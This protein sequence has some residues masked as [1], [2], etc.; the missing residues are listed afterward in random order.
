MIFEISNE[1]MYCQIKVMAQ[2]NLD[3]L[4]LLSSNSHTPHIVTSSSHL[5]FHHPIHMHHCCISMT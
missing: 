1:M 4:H 2:D 5:D 3:R